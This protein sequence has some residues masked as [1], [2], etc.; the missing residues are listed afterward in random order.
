MTTHI[1]CGSFGICVG[2]QPGVALMVVASIGATVRVIGGHG[3]DSSRAV[4]VRQLP[5]PVPV[6]GAGGETL[7]ERMGDL[8][9]G[10]ED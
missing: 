6:R 10:M 7:V 5:R 2:Q 1:I 4:N 3:T 8:Y 9:Q